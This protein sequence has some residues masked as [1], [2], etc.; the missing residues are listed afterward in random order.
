MTRISTTIVINAPAKKVWEILKDFQAYPLWNPFI[1][2]IT[3]K[4]RNCLRISVSPPGG[5]SMKF[6]PVII[7]NTK[8]KE[9]AWQGKLFLKGIFDGYHSFSLEEKKTGQTTFT[10]SE[11]FSG[12]LVPLFKKSLE[13]STLEGFKQMN[14][15]LKARAEGKG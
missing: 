3:K 13:N 12:F 15:A 10:H 9:F 7:Q 4:D 8:E 6:E 5:K 2:S 1:T 11:K 14:I